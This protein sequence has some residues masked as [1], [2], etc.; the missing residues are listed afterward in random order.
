[1]TMPQ[2]DGATALDAQIAAAAAGLDL[3]RHI[4]E[5]ETVGYTI[6]PDVFPLDLCQRGAAHMDE[7]L[8]Q[9][10]ETHQGPVS[11][12]HPI[13]GSIM[14]ELFSAPRL[15]AVASAL[16]RAPRSELR[17]F[18]QVLIR[19]ARVPHEKIDEPGPTARGWHVDDVFAPEQ[20]FATP[21][22]T[23]QQMFAVLRDIEPGAGGTMVV[24]SSHRRVMAAAKEHS[25]GVDGITY[26]PEVWAAYDRDALLTGIQSR[27]RDFGI[28]PDTGV[29]LFCSAGSLVVFC[30]GCLHS[31]SENRSRLGASRYVVVQSFYH[32]TAADLLQKRYAGIRYLKSF[33]RD[34][35]AAVSPA[36]RPMLRGRALW[37]EAMREELMHFSSRGWFIS[38]QPVVGEH[39]LALIKQL[40]QELEPEWRDTEFPS[41]VNRSAALFLMVL[42]AARQSGLRIATPEAREPAAHAMIEE[43][44]NLALAAALLDLDERFASTFG[45]DIWKGIVLSGCGLGD[46]A[47]WLEDNV[48][49]EQATSVIVLAGLSAPERSWICTPAAA[50]RIAPKR[51]FWWS[52]STNG[53]EKLALAVRHTFGEREIASW[54][55]QRQKFWGVFGKDGLLSGGT[56]HL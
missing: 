15:L 56:A 43:K 17:L 54:H 5:V 46:P 39:N 18:E 34:T 42:K 19:T 52:Y 23:Y 32:E 38:P 41:G 8:Q 49:R 2:D 1:M 6:V 20:F 7:V 3:Q 10:M 12:S 40:A 44:A 14:G 9:G 35:H 29:E 37:G 48:T 45:R 27:P 25:R 33:H 16:A 36:L 55:E 28:D 30:P 11:R 51:C 4:S 53:N 13:P 47:D 21:R 50:C 24:P 26:D 31:S 22:E